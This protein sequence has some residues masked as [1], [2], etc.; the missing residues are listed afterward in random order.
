MRGHLNPGIKEVT[1]IGGGVAGLMA[2]EALL[3]AG[4]RVTIYEASSRLGGMI[5][6]QITPFGIAEGAAH[7]FRTGE[8]I[9]ALC[10]RLN[11]NV[12]EGLTRK[13]FIYR[14]QKMRQFPL[15]I[16]EVFALA[17]S[18]LFHRAQ[19]AGTLKAWAQ[20]HVGAGAQQALFTPLSQGIFGTAPGNLFQPL[21]FPGLTLPAGRTLVAHLFCRKR[22]APKARM[23]MAAPVEG[24][25][26]LTEA[27]AQFVTGHPH[28]TVVLNHAVKKLPKAKNIILSAPA[29][30][31]AKL[32]AEAS[33]QTSKALA[34]VQSVPLVAV[35][36][37]FSGVKA[38]AGI[39][40]L[41]AEGQDIAA[42]G[43]L[44]NSAALPARLSPQAEEKG[45]VSL[46]FMYG[47]SAAKRML[48]AEAEIK[49]QVEKD[50]HTLFGPAA[51]AQALYPACWRE[52]LPQYDENLAQALS[53][54][55][56]DWCHGQG[57]VL[58]GNYTGD[59]S[60]RG[61]AEGAAKL[62]QPFYQ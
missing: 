16:P 4:V 56:K 28:A 55:D 8:A 45:L 57:R 17:R 29:A 59:I 19:K 14:Y 32:L 49:N 26:A 61:L 3:R 53:M 33:P 36:A 5:S 12:A 48:K 22:Q 46:T 35:T 23:Y 37:F 40:V 34:K 2:A 50:A 7:S 60:L 47:G 42:N 10:K 41:M 54:A 30:V 51:K 24:M 25:G 58:Y 21:A 13:K 38:P 39:G 44:F 62:A 52:A 20:N 43:V 11:I 18:S 9:M 27:L 1:I 6:T 15:T 31:A